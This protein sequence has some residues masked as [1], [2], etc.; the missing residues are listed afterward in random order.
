MHLAQALEKRPPNNA[1]STIRPLELSFTLLFPVWLLAQLATHLVQIP[2]KRPRTLLIAPSGRPNS[3]KFYCFFLFLLFP[4]WAMHGVRTS[5]KRFRRALVAPS[6]RSNSCKFPDSFPQW[7]MHVV[8]P[9]K[10]NASGHLACCADLEKYPNTWARPDNGLFP[11]RLPARSYRCPQ[12]D[13]PARGPI[14]SRQLKA[15]RLAY[16]PRSKDALARP[17]RSLRAH[18]GVLSGMAPLA[19][20]YRQPAAESDPAHL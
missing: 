5:K 15:T 11:E 18:V 14:G 19:G 7:S 12:R 1:S 10:K 20:L 13:C 6:G 17:A 8:Q 9:S 2:K 4:Q 16:M 3:C